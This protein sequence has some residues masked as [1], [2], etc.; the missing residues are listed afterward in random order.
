MWN[1]I[2]SKGKLKLFTKWALLECDDEIGKMYRSLYS[3]EYFYKSKIQ[4]PLWGTHISIIRGETLL[5]QEIKTEL[6][7]LAVEFYYIPEVKT[8]GIHFWLPVLCP[9]L[10]DIRELFGLG[11]SQVA[12]HLSIGNILDGS[13]YIQP[14][15]FN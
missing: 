1:L 5:S 10:D 13:E 15:R 6:V 11:A 8:N 14:E 12:Y 9:I 4:K 7:D 3:L 2:K